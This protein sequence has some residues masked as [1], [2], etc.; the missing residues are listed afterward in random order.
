MMHEGPPQGEQRLALNQLL[1][2]GEIKYAPEEIDAL[3]E[4]L[5]EPFQDHPVFDGVTIRPIEAAKVPADVQK[6]IREGGYQITTFTAVRIE[7]EVPP[8]SS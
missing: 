3:E 6:M 5:K 7:R 1:S 4:E 2:S 8:L